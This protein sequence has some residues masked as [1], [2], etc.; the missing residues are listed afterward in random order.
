MSVRVIACSI[1]LLKELREDDMSK[2][3]DMTQQLR[4]DALV[5]ALQDVVDDIYEYERVN[6]L[7]PNPPR[8][9]C[10]DSV[11]R[12]KAVLSVIATHGE[13]ADVQAT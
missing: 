2:T 7:S 1:H 13:F 3:G 11:T 4:E 12:A 6:N 5:K 8:I 10:W 9:K